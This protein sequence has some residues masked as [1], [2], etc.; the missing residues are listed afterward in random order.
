MDIKALPVIA[1]IFGVAVITLAI[2]TTI[3][4]D[5]RTDLDRDSAAVVNESDAVSLVWGNSTNMT[6]DYQYVSVS[7]VA[8]CTGTGHTTVGSGN[9]TV[10]SSLGKIQCDL[11]QSD[12][13]GNGTF[14]HDGDVMCVNYT[15]LVE[16]YSWNTT[17]KGTQGLFSIA[18]WLPTI[19]LVI[20]AIIV[21]GILILL[22]YIKVK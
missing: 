15:H 9:Y 10:Y 2:C 3:I 11:N 17:T 21:L 5:I 4:L 22:G 12:L 8:N 6:L 19:G 1:I 18:Q 14:P 7:T 16:D 20:G 13:T